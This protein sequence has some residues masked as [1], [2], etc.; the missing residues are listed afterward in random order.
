MISAKKKKKLENLPLPLSGWYRFRF[1]TFFSLR[2]TFG[3]DSLSFQFK[4]ILESQKKWHYF[5]RC[6][7]YLSIEHYQPI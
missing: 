7:N 2:D 1:E 6:H 3:S 5:I 4:F